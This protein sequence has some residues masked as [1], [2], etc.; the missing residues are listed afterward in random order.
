MWEQR[1]NQIVGNWGQF[2]SVMSQP[3]GPLNA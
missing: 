1:L 2:G 3:A